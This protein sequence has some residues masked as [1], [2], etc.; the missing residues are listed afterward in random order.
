MELATMPLRTLA[1][2]IC[3][4]LICTA[5]S[6]AEPPKVDRELQLRTELQQQI[7]AAWRANDFK[8]L[9][10]MGEDILAKGTKTFNGMPKLAP[11]NYDLDQQMEIDWP[12]NWKVAGQ[13]AEDCSCKA[14][15]PAH[16]AEAEQ[17]WDIIGHKLNAWSNQYPLSNIAP[18]ARMRYFLNRAW[19]FRGGAYSDKVLP[20]AWPKFQQYLDEAS[21]T[22]QASAP[23]RFKNPAW[24]GYAIQ[25][26]VANDGPVDQLV[27]EMPEHGQL[28][29]VAFDYAATFLQ[30]KWG[31]SET[32]IR[33]L[34]SKT[35]QQAPKKEGL[36]FYARLYWILL[37]SDDRSLR[38]QSLADVDRGMLK[39]GFNIILER[40][41]EVWNY[42]GAAH[43]ACRINDPAYFEQATSWLGIADRFKGKPLQSINCA[44]ADFSLPKPGLWSWFWS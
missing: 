38:E 14:P 33:E 5:A 32:A 18:V 16:Y 1:T 3:L 28:Y 19:F 23:I 34:I 39:A 30:P 25:L 7:A 35:V 15:D 37:E 27:A 31:G 24:Y 22:A 21:K 26:A 13:V 11:Y 36:E 6:A 29:T 42:T 9:E 40:Y 41:P 17:R 10:T 12:D 2:A 43:I 20:Q 8:T 44:T 4:T